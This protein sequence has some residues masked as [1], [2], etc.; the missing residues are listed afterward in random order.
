MERLRR[1]VTGKIAIQGQFHRHGGG[2]ASRFFA[3]VRRN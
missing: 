1:G 2:A 3:A